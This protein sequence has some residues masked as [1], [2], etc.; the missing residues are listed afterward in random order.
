LVVVG[1]NL[2]YECY[3]ILSLGD[4]PVIWL[5]RDEDGYLSLSV[6]MLTTSGQPRLELLENF[7]VLHGKPEKDFECPP[8]EN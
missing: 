6:R 4:G 1:G 3:T 2:F 7:W 5:T 8:S